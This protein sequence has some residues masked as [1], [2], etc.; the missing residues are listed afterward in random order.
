[1]TQVLGG[2]CHVRIDLQSFSKVFFRPSMDCL[3]DP[4]HIELTLKLPD[5]IDIEGIDVV[6]AV[7]VTTKNSW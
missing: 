2:F 4:N 5:H 1:M 3:I 7:M 6:A